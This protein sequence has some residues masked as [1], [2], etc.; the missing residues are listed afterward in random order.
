MS[1]LTIGLILGFGLA[2]VVVLVVALMRRGRWTVGFGPDGPEFPDSTRES[3]E[4]SCLRVSQ[5]PD[6]RVVVDKDGKTQEY[7]SLD[8]LPD[9]V[10]AAFEQAR[11]M[12]PGTHFNTQR[13]VR[14]MPPE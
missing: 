5:R 1:Q 2:L 12:G 6:G 8:D 3:V 10:R 7:A 4:R 9:D 13:T 14:R 11:Q